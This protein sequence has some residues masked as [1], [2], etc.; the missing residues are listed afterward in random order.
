MKVNEKWKKNDTDDQIQPKMFG[1]GSMKSS[2][3][4]TPKQK[5]LIRPS[6]QS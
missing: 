4:T 1:Q 6:T 3:Q 5:L 2:M